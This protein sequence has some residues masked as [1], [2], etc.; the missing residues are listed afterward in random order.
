MR[1]T[2]ITLLCS[3][4][5]F[6]LLLGITTTL[7]SSPAAA[8][9]YVATDG[10][11]DYN[12]DGTDDQVQINQAM[13][14]VASHS[15]YT[16]VHL[17]S[18]TYIIGDTIFIHSDTILEG[19]SGTVVKLEDEC[20]WPSQKGLIEPSGEGAHSFKIHDFEVDGNLDRQTYVV[21]QMGEPSI[22]GRGYLDMF[23]AS[24]GENGD[25][26]APY[27]FEIYNMYFHDG[28][29]DGIKIK[30]DKT[31]AGMKIHDNTFSRTGHDDIFI[32]LSKDVHIYDNDFTWIYGD[33]GVRIENTDDVVITNNTLYTKTSDP[34]G[35]SGIYL[36]LT[37]NVHTCHNYTVAYNT[38]R[39]VQEMGIVVCNRVA[40]T[41]GLDKAKDLYIHHN[42]IYNA[43]GNRGYGGGIQVNGW[44]NTVIENNVIDGCNGDGIVTRNRFEMG[45]TTGYKIYIR[46][47]VITN[48][49]YYSGFSSSGHGINNYLDSR[50]DLILE[51]NNVWNNEK[52]NYRNVD[53]HASDLNVDPLFVDRANHDYHLKP[54]SPII[55]AG[56]GVYVSA[57]ST[58]A[59]ILNTNGGRTADEG[60]SLSFVVSRWIS[61]ISRWV[62]DSIKSP[63]IDS[64]TV[65]VTVQE[66]PSD[67]GCG[68]LDIVRG[69]AT[70]DGDL[71]DWQNTAGITIYGASDRNPEE[72]NT[73]TVKAMYDDTYL[74]FGYDVTDTTLRANMVRDDTSLYLDDSVEIY[75]DTLDNNG[76]V[77]QADDYHFIINLNGAVVDDVGTGSEK[78][79]NYTSNILKSVRLQGSKNDASD[80]DTGYMIEVAIPWSDIGGQPSNDIVGL[81]L[82]INDLDNAG[83]IYFFNW[84]NLTGSYAVPEDWGDAII[85]GINNTAPV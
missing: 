53:S 46:N 13:D 80:T 61:D 72:D 48:T 55:D 76:A 62:I 71:S 34:R 57:G 54:N 11:G 85:T 2:T 10:S 36:S 65:L 16:T 69:T 79:Y 42:L 83:D 82:A 64:D 45:D 27:D 31:S 58:P 29:N 39:D 33:C 50:H 4:L 74:Y 25:Q 63:F 22:H 7:R 18:G 17:K 67:T 9:V 70:I 75:L 52:G 78:D 12:C 24:S 56:M 21:T 28:A 43:I 26:S 49:G 44:N 38:I 32:T 73:A 3:L 5:I 41:P 77:M 6:V 35:I 68:N 20:G 51:N 1:K 81:F 47:N 66:I 15:E 40:G 19:E 8:T 37:H 14:F 30:G 23:F 60:S 84:C 59:P